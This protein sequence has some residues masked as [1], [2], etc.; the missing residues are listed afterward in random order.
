V[1]NQAERIVVGTAQWGGPY[2][3][4]NRTGVPDR[5]E[6][7]RMLARA[8][9]AGI[10][11]LDTARAYGESESVIGTLVGGDP[12]WS[13]VTKVP[14][15]GLAD[16][17]ETVAIDAARRAI[18]AS[19]GALRRSRLDV[20]LLHDPDDRT[21]A[22]GG[23]WSALRELRRVGAIGALGI[24]ARCPSEALA[25]LEADGVEVV[26]VATSLLDSR[27]VRADFVRMAEAAARRVFIR[28]AFL[29]GVAHVRPED[30]P[31]FLRTA[32]PLL[33]AIARWAHARAMTT[34]EACLLYLRDVCTCP[35]VLGME[36]DS[37]L[38]ANIRAWARAPLDPGEIADLEALVPE[39]PD[40]VVD[41]SKWPRLADR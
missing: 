20:V 11:T 13:I 17:S 37:Q 34:A 2:G 16:A 15:L 6:I 1:V 30:L 5:S 28:S 36:S 33:T 41:P 22:R 25:G 27:L 24:S 14:P 8:R 12:Q 39:L 3:I 40:A 32:R 38:E 18:D 10:T 29:Q 35:I 23:A 9:A 31:S 7:A 19:L 4:A 26:Q 21:R